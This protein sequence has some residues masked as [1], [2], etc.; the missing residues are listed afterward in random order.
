[1]TKLD[2]LFAAKYAAEAEMGKA[3]HALSQAQKVFAKAKR[4]FEQARDAFLAEAE[5]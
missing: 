5:K 1:M 3:R 4:N 2:E